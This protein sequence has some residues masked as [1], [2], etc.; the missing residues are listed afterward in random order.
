MEEIWRRYGG[1]MEGIWGQGPLEEIWGQ[2]PFLSC[3]ARPGASAGYV[4]S[5]LTSLPRTVHVP[6][7]Q[8]GLPQG[9]TYGT[10]WVRVPA[11]GILTAYRPD[12][13]PRS[14]VIAPGPF[15]DVGGASISFSDIANAGKGQ[16]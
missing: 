10:Y 2:G 5:T 14:V 16:G 15:A 8:G 7:A 13:A 12:V 9:P 3:P 1:D 11:T 4:Q 6:E